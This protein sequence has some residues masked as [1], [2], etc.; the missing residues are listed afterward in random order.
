MKGEIIMIYMRA[1]DAKDNFIY[2]Q[3]G[4]SLAIHRYKGT[5]ESIVIPGIIGNKEV[6]YVGSYQ[7]EFLG[8]K[9]VFSPI[10]ESIELSDGIVSIRRN[11]F[12][13]CVT[14]KKILLPDTL[15]YIGKY[16]FADCYSLQEVRIPRNVK[17]IQDYAFSY[18]T[19]LEKLFV[20][21]SIEFFGHQTGSPK[22]D[23]I[24]Y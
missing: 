7:G 24:F 16:A 20:P 1:K 17:N 15:E 9:K 8:R 13:K 4:E 3:E 18:C 23:I 12:I 6:K 5:D 11:C 10:A 22:M 2:H 14:L 19:H 21:E